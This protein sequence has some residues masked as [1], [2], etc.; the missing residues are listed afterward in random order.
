MT[1]KQVIQSNRLHEV[2]PVRRNRDIINDFVMNGYEVS[3][4][5][6]KYKVSTGWINVI[7]YKAERYCRLLKPIKPK[8]VK[9]TLITDCDL[10]TRVVH[11]CKAMEIDT[12]EDLSKISK[13]ELLSVRNLGVKSIDAISY[14]MKE[15][16]LAWG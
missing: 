10:P 6:I 13:V 12:L 8:R 5:A 2:T 7:L 16:G 14:A 1:I 9:G 4:L 3:S 15:R 11:Y